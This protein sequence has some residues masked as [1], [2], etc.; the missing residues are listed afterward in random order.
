MSLQELVSQRQAAE[1]QREN[2]FAALEA[3]FSRLEEELS[4]VKSTVTQ[5]VEPAVE[6]IPVAVTKVDAREFQT[7]PMEDKRNV[8]GSSNAPSTA[9]DAAVD[10]PNPSKATTYIK[11]DYTELADAAFSNCCQSYKFIP[12]PPLIAFELMKK[13]GERVMLVV[14]AY[15]EKSVVATNQVEASSVRALFP[16]QRT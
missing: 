2:E 3:K 14:D 10:S 9:E 5:L 8:Q 1:R 6:A 7:S 13:T 16:P 12:S 11:N 4:A 15:T